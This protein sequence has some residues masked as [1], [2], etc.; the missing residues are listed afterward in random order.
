MDL[1]EARMSGDAE[2]P[3]LQLSGIAKHYGT[4]RA[5]QDAAL[6]VHRNEV[7]ALVG[8]NGAGKTTIAKLLTPNSLLLVSS[9]KSRGIG[10]GAALPGRMK[11]PPV[12]VHVCDKYFPISGAIESPVVP[13]PNS[14]PPNRELRD[15]GTS[16]MSVS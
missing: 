15:A 6:T 16:R 3:I 14:S 9:G 13:D 4:V 8:D 2:P 12:N 11:R 10:V 5:L 1:Q 7:V